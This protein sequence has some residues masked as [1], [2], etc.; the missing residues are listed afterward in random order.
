MGLLRDAFKWVV[1]LTDN[2]IDQ[3]DVEA[4]EQK[5]RGVKRLL[6]AGQE[7]RGDVLVHEQRLGGVAYGHILRF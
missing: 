1:G 6:H 3:I 2:R 7:R 4:L 5:V